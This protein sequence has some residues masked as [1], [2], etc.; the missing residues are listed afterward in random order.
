MKMYTMSLYESGDST[1]EV[2]LRGLFNGK[3]ENKKVAKTEF[4]KLAELIVRGGWPETIGLN[5]ENARRITKSYWE[6]VLEKD[7]TEID[8]VKR[9][10]SKMEMLIR[11]LARNETSI[12]PITVLV[13]DIAESTDED[14]LLVSRNTVTDYLDVLDRLHLIEN[15]NSFMYKI[16]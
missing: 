1:G 6:A 11:S 8:G 5:A 2:S 10:K 3:V 12:S 16:S 9:D 13:K 7:I 15:Q 14:E 4:S